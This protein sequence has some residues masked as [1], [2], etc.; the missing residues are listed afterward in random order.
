MLPKLAK[1]LDCRLIPSFILATGRAPVCIPSLVL[2]KR[3]RRQEI[4]FLPIRI[5]YL[6]GKGIGKVKTSSRA[7]TTPSDKH[8]NRNEYRALREGAF[9]SDSEVRKLPGR[10]KGVIK[11]AKWGGGH[12]AWK[13]FQGEGD[14]CSTLQK[15]GAL[16][17]EVS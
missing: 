16:R 11:R 15:R 10:N 7:I 13:G 8:V 6:L 5:L 14:P 17:W 9:I 4:L 2:S 12:G 3:V 1:V